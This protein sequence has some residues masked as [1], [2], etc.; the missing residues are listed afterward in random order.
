VSD[1]GLH[2]PSDASGNETLEVYAFLACMGPAAFA[3]A[4]ARRLVGPADADP[5]RTA[6]IDWLTAPECRE[7]VSREVG[8]HL[9]DVLSHRARVSSLDL[10]EILPAMLEVDLALGYQVLR[11]LAAA[12]PPAL[13]PPLGDILLNLALAARRDADAQPDARLACLVEALAALPLEPGDRTRLFLALSQT[14]RGPEALRRVSLS[15]LYPARP[16]DMVQVLAEG[17]DDA[18]RVL[19]NGALLRDG[20]RDAFKAACWAALELDGGQG[21]GLLARLDPLLRGPEAGLRVLESTVRAAVLGHV[22]RALERGR[23]VQ[24]RMPPDPDARTLRL[25]SLVAPGLR[26]P[27]RT[28]FCAWMLDR[29][30]E[31]IVQVDRPEPPGEALVEAIVGA[32]TMHEDPPAA[33][34]LVRQALLQAASALRLRVL[35]VGSPSTADQ[36]RARAFERFAGLLGNDF[37]RRRPLVGVLEGILPLVTDLSRVPTGEVPSGEFPLPWSDEPAPAP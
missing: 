4:A 33:G 6:A 26:E 30:A 17:N 9:A 7:D 34:A 27:G 32:A 11:E 10:G 35:A 13:A 29:A 18:L 37:R 3:P 16:R 19:L 22:E 23:D 36:A 14:L 8:R 15:A 25:L 5:V 12:A 20:G 24:D 21:L 31:R 1:T 28:Q 2:T